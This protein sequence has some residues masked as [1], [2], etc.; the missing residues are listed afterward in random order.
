MEFMQYWKY[1][2]SKSR[3]KVFTFRWEFYFFFFI[4]ALK[5]F[6]Y[7]HNVVRI[8]IMDRQN[9]IYYNKIGRQNCCN[10]EQ[11]L[12]VVI[13]L[14]NN[15]SCNLSVCTY[16]YVYSCIGRIFLLN[17]YHKNNKKKSFNLTPLYMFTVCSKYIVW[18]LFFAKL[19]VRLK[20]YYFKNTF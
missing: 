2:K 5:F 8:T 4:L 1:A 17:F 3:V 14:Q 16:L 13:S 6:L 19:S 12:K 9:R 10:T 11:I 15:I 7:V 20:F 18:V